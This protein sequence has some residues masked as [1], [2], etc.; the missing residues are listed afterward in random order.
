MSLSD[1]QNSFEINPIILVGGITGAGMV[2]LGTILNARMYPT[3]LLSSSVAAPNNNFFG[4]FRILPGHTLMDNAVATYPFANQ[5]TAANA[6]ITQPLKLS[7]EMVAPA[8][9]VM[10]T[11]IKRAT[12]GALKTLLDNHTAQ[13]GWYNVSTPTYVYQG[14]LLT[15]IIDSSTEMEGSQVQ[16]RWIWNFMQPLLTSEA[17]Q[18]AQNQA[19][20]KVSS[21]TVNAGDPPGANAIQ[22]SYNQPSANTIQN[23]V[24]SA[25]QPLG[26]NIA[27]TGLPTTP[28][29]INSLGSGTLQF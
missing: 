4:S 17:A 5:T 21:Q 1:Y 27:S 7:L 28:P 19:M 10:T 20:S 3:G 9:N 6:V 24:P 18:A 25:T 22:T 15:S 14:C 11:S 8:D 13:G 12:F 29:S 26:S 23:F 16:T 2:P